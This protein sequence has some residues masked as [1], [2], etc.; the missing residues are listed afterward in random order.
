MQLCVFVK[1]LHFHLLKTSDAKVVRLKTVVKSIGI[2]PWGAGLSFGDSSLSF[3]A[4]WIGHAA[5]AGGVRDVLVFEGICT[6]MPSA[7]L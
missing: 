1:V 7:S 4:I 3:F 2:G 6:A 5:A